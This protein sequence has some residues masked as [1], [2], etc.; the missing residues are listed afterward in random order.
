MNKGTISFDKIC[1]FKYKVHIK[2]LI[3]L[4]HYVESLTR[5][6]RKSL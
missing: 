4:R 2:L 5:F 6:Y 3:N 1:W